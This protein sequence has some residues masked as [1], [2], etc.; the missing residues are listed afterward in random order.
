MKEKLPFDPG[1]SDC[2]E[3]IGKTFDEL[4]G[5]LVSIHNPKQKRARFAALYPRI[6]KTV[7]ENVAFYLGCLLWAAYLKNKPGVEIEGNTCLSPEYDRENSLYEI[8]ALIDYVSVGLNRDSKY[9]L[10]KTYEPSPLCIRILEVYKDFLDKNEGLHK[11]KSTDD[12]LLPKSIEALGT[13][14]LEGI[15]KDIKAAIA[16][17]DI[18]SLMKYGNKI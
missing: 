3:H 2:I 10:N 1:Y 12:I 4:H 14:E 16:A 8:N 5:A 11:T 17:K 9:Y 7:E 18:L 6:V 13:Q 15:F